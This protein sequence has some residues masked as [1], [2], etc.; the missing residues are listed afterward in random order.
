MKPEEI[1]FEIWWKR[2]RRKY[3]ELDEFHRHYLEGETAAEIATRAGLSES[4]V[5][6][7][8]ERAKRRLLR[9]LTGAR[10]GLRAGRSERK[11]GERISP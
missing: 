10:G 11:S 3:P 5:K 7:R 8:I 9:I 1:E 6:R 4:G 2:L